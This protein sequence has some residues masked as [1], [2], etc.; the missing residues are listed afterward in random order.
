VSQS[1]LAGETKEI[2]RTRILS[3]RLTYFFNPIHFYRAQIKNVGL[4]PFT[5]LLKERRAKNLAEAYPQYSS[6][7]LNEF[8][9]TQPMYET[10]FNS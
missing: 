7:Y 6:H 9:E 10:I 8:V 2:T 1:S 4:K 5:A 3:A